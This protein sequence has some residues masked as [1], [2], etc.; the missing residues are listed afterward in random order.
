[1]ELFSLP[2]VKRR[3]IVEKKIPIRSAWTDTCHDEVGVLAKELCWGSERL[4]V[5]N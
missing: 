2:I 1:M 4:L 5:V 3:P